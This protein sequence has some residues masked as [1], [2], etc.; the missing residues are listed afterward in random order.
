MFRARSVPPPGLGTVGLRNK[1]QSRPLFWVSPVCGLSGFGKCFWVIRRAPHPG[2]YVAY[3]SL[4]MWRL[5]SLVQISL[6]MYPH[7]DRR[8]D[9]HLDGNSG[10]EDPN[11]HPNPLAKNDQYGPAQTFFI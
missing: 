4:S 8:G 3:A 9:G 1:K 2:K 7:A 6:C 10:P 5:E 11:F